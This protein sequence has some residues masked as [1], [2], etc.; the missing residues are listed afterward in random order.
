[1]DGGRKGGIKANMGREQKEA[2]LENTWH[3]GNK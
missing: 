2:K 1:M 3:I